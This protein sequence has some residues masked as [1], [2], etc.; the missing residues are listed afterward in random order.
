MNI[1][2]LQSTFGI[3]HHSALAEALSKIGKVD[4]Y[5]SNK[6]ILELI[7]D[8]ERSQIKAVYIEYLELMR[9]IAARVE[10]FQENKA[11]YTLQLNKIFDKKIAS[12]VKKK[13]NKY[14]IGVLLSDSAL[15]T[16][17]VLKDKGTIT[18][19][20]RGSQHII[21]CNSI[22]KSEY[23]KEGVKFKFD[24][25]HIERCLE[26]YNV[27]DYIL[28]PSDYAKNSFIKNGVQNEKIIVVPYG[29]NFNSNYSLK[30]E[31]RKDSILI[32]GTFSIQK[33]AHIIAKISKIISNYHKIEIVHCGAIS[34][35]GRHI[36]EKYELE[37]YISFVGYK[38]KKELNSIMNNSMMLLHP[39]VQ[40]GLAL[41]IPEALA[42]GMHVVCSGISGG[43]MYVKD[44]INGYVIEGGAE[45]YLEAIIKIRE[46]THQSLTIKKGDEC[47]VECSVSNYSK[48]IQK[49]ITARI[50][51]KNQKIN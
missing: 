29:T 8:N 17:K 13:E 50:K 5:F 47:I 14:N 9:K 49:E 25:R 34:K 23:L 6:K 27:A 20:D 16:I 3:F 18:F 22:L 19:L 35:D 38:S 39:S 36:I 40:D 28:V 26:E 2:I 32:A 31:N 33:G 42:S 41:V 11:A 15:E 7:N 10:D 24:E 37:K 46:R 12:I 48:K 4:L 45:D 21:D 44:G 51:I 30:N 1:K 43:G